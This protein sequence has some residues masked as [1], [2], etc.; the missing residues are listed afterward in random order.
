[1]APSPIHIGNN[2][3]L[4]MT[5]YGAG[6]GKIKINKTSD[7]YEAILVEKHNPREGIA[8]DQQTP[9]M[10]GEYLWVI[11]PKDAGILGKQLACYHISDLNNPVWISGKE[12]RY[13]IGPYIVCRDKLYLFNDDGELFMFS[14]D[15]NSVTLLDRY[16]VIEGIDAWGPMALADGYLLV[17]DSRNMLCLYVGL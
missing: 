16:K 15:I 7:G 8:S 6:G 11:L 1:M 3:L 4:V 17:R 14:Q 12:N 5:C 13:G 2:E 10:M 9:I